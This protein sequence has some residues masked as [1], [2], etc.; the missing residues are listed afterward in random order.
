[1]AKEE[2]FISRADAKRVRDKIAKTG[3]QA[4]ELLAKELT[5]IR[6]ERETIPESWVD[7]FRKVADQLRRDYRLEG[8]AAGQE[9]AARNQEPETPADPLDGL[10][11]ISD[12]EAA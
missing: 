7:K 2:P 4:L 8:Q 3:E 9:P 12:D 10:K 11:V 1:M 6:L 5:T